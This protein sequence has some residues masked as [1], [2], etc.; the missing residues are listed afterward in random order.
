MSLASLRAVRQGF[1]HK[2]RLAPT[3]IHFASPSS[4]EASL[5]ISIAAGVKMAPA[6]GISRESRGAD[7]NR[8]FAPA[9]PGGFL[10]ANRAS[11]SNCSAS[12]PFVP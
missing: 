12:R 7:L 1:S 5:S 3:D 2:R 11:A 9:V 4:I 6:A 10:P 8:R